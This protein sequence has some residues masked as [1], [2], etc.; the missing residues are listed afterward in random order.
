MAALESTEANIIDRV[1]APDFERL[2]SDPAFQTMVG[3]TGGTGWFLGQNLVNPPTDDPDV[4]AAIAAAVNP[5]EISDTIFKGTL[6]P[7]GE[8][9][10][11]QHARLHALPGH[12]DQVRPRCCWSPAR[13]RGMGDG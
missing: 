1:P 2:K 3:A 4:R 11:A 10:R 12:A 6:P 9:P 13:L 5:A 7:L 8:H